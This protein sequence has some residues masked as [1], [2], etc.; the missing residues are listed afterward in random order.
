MLD[1]IDQ[2][3]LVAEGQ[4]DDLSFLQIRPLWFAK[5]P[6]RR[7]KDFVAAIYLVGVQPHPLINGLQ[8]TDFFGAKAA[9]PAKPSL[10]LVKT[11]GRFST[12]RGIAEPPLRVVGET[13]KLRALRASSRQV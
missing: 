12:D 3:A 9:R 4:S 7:C 10:Q 5:P 1:A 2:P 6:F 11:K 8:Q 13:A